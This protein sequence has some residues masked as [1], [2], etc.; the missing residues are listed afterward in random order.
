MQD[1]GTWSEQEFG[2]ARF[3]DRRLT[4]RLVQVGAEVCA[5]PAGQITQVFTTS[6]D[7]EGAFRLVESDAVDVNEVKRASYQACRERCDGKPYVFVAVDG[8]SLSLTDNKR[9]KGTGT[10]G[11]RKVGARGLQVMT[12][13]A[14]AP[15]GTPMGLCGQTWWARTEPSVKR[16]CGGRDKRPVAVKETRH[17]LDVMGQVRQVFSG[18]AAPKPWFQ[19]DRGGDAWPVIL[20]G[21]HD[22]QLFTVRATYDRRLR[23]PT[24]D[25]SRRYLR[26]TMEAE[27]ILGR[28][29]LKVLGANG[30]K[31][32]TARMELRSRQV[33]LDMRVGSKR[34]V[35]ATLWAVLARESPT[36]VPEGEKPID[37]LLLTT[38]PATTADECYLVLFG[39]TQRWRI[40]EFHRLWKTGACNVEDSQLRAP[41][42]PRECLV[43]GE[44]PDS[45][46]WARGAG[47]RSRERRGAGTR[48][49][50]RR[51]TWAR[52]ARARARGTECVVRARSGGRGREGQGRARGGG[53]EWCGCEAWGRARE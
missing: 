11:S 52:S 36:T 22:A 16:K 45:G 44:P 14:V 8:S 35:T 26:Q 13:L 32:R 1:A 15:E 28:Y 19:L 48:S 10:V 33:T 37:W 34:R 20:D 7:R 39:Y 49:R 21:L 47:T 12:A 29:E 51:G 50:E 41:P 4:R 43:L 17:W 27:P 53:A 40:E 5:N 46:V 25:G 9:S 31:P 30:R 38:H 18:D 42:I 3:G 6:A 24:P 23:L 2:G